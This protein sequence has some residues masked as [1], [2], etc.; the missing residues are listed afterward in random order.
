LKL[1]GDQFRRTYGSDALAPP[2]GFGISSLQESIIGDTRSSLL[3]L[4]GAVFFVLVIACANVAN[5]LLARASARKRELATRVAL[6]AGRGQIIR[7]L[8]IESLTLSLTGGFLGLVLGFVGVRLLLNISPGDIPRLGEKRLGRDSRSEHTVVH[9][10]VSVLTGILFGLVPA[11]SASR[12]NL[13]AT[14]NESS[15]RS[16]IGFRGGKLRSFLVVSEIA[17]AL[18]LVIGA[19]LLIRTFLKLQAVD[20]GFDSHNVLTMAVSISGNRFQKT[21]GVAQVIRDGTERLK[22][23]PGVTNAAA[24]C[25][26][27][28]QGGFGVPFDI[29]G[30]PKGN[31]PSTGGGG[32]YSVSWSCFGTFKIP[33]LHGRTFNEHDDGASPGVIII[34]EAIAK[35]YWPKA[36][37]LKDRLRTGVNM[38]PVF[39]EP[40]RQ[41]IGIVGDTHDSGLNRDPRPTMYFSVSQMPDAETALNSR[42]AP[43]WWVVRSNVDRRQVRTARCSL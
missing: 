23:V 1:V 22:A 19:A 25:C 5:L 30:R 37:P 13:A 40:P 18:I 24:A 8:L 14:L 2:D 7:Q 42:V 15:S 27:P 21:A 29:V 16:S 11:I 12:P 39:V 17:P 43:L 3:V 36:D 28:L 6:G 35:Q 33:L 10:G 4:L 38:G 20:R 26:L 34:N 41:I 32:Y 31:D 9:R